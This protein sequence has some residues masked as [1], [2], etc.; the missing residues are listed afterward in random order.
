M[1]KFIGRALEAGETLLKSVTVYP[2]YFTEKDDMGNPKWL[3]DVAGQTATRC[4]W[5]PASREIKRLE[6]GEDTK[7]KHILHLP[8][9]INEYDEVLGTEEGTL[10]VAVE[11]HV[12]TTDKY[13]N[14]IEWLVKALYDHGEYLELDLTD[15]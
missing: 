5:E 12:K 15:I 13:D 7:T 11:D 3:F 1:R 9:L 4:G 10:A 8:R 2:R 14:V 6:F